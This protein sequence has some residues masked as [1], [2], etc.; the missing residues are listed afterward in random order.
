MPGMTKGERHELTQLVRKRERV[1]KIQAQE[2]SAL[3]LAEFDAQSAKIYHF[4]ED[5]VWKRVQAEA[6]KAIGEAQI[7]IAARCAELSIPA[8]F[9]PG[10]DM[11]W[12]GR[13]HNAVAERRAELRRAAKS[14][15][16]AIE[17][18][19]V[20]KIERLSLQAQTEII[21]NGLESDAA[22]EFLNAMPA[23]EA[24]MPPIAFDE[25]QS[26]VETRRSQRRLSYDA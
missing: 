16:D 2:R 10:I 26:L 7:Q 15:V 6:A 18:E 1:M 20:T 21:A 9:A 17:K 13:G 22:K 24:L 4:D 23:L 19:A 11:F 5:P 8:E 25:I 14:R 12:H 3:L